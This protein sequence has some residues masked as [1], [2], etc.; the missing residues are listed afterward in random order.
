MTD[1]ATGS[2][3]SLSYIEESTFGTTPAGNFQNLPF[4]SHTLDLSKDRVAGNDIQS[5]R[6]NRIDRHGNRQVGG[7]IVFDLR[8]GDFDTILESAMLNTWVTN[9]A[10]TEDVLDVGVTP[11]YFSI[12][13]Y[14]ADIDYARLFTGCTVNT[15]N[16]SIAPN[17]MIT[18]TVGVVGK[19]MTIS[20]TEKTQNASS[21]N[22]P[23]DSYSGVLQMADTGGTLADVGVVTS[24]DLTLNNGF[25]PLF[26][27]GDDS[28]PALEYGSAVV[29]GTMTAYYE[30]DTIINRFLN[31]TETD[32]LVSVDDPTGSNTYGFRMPR[33]KINGAAVPVGG[34]ESRIITMPFV[35][36]YDDTYGT[37]FRITR[38]GSA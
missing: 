20:Q 23:F 24:L 11:K 26:V 34:P 38:P 13:D 31:E 17:Q 12:E 27:I 36:L 29:E 10:P 9:T 15:M 16:L 7:D 8:A 28:A 25:G 3:A 6:M 5:D 30:D 14:Q 33:A 21:T 4:T 32:I 35:A 1:F 18:T 19:D 37:N 2:R 22:S